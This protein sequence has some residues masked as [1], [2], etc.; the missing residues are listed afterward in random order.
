MALQT[1]F[2][3]TVFKVA[4]ASV[5]TLL[6]VAPAEAQDVAPYGATIVR[7]A[8]L[9]IDPAQLEAYQT[10]VKEEMAQSVR[11]EPGVISISAVALKDHPN[12]IRFFEIYASDA[13]YQSHIQSPHFL[14]YVRITRDMI[15]SRVLLETVPVQLSTN[16]RPSSVIPEP[17]ASSSEGAHP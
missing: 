12:H 7:I 3:D 6:V 14:E 11:V 5:L 10:A 1:R 9:V 15:Q 8:E 13:A 16:P 17:A 4:L 2:S